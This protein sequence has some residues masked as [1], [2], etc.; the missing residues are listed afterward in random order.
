MMI[1]QAENVQAESAAQEFNIIGTDNKK[2]HFIFSRNMKC[3][4]FVFDA[5]IFARFH[6]GKEFY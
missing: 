6:K 2:K 3:F 5:G 4:F 1:R